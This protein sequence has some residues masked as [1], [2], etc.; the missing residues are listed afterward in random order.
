MP[1]TFDIRFRLNARAI[2]ITVPAEALLLDVVRDRLG[3]KGAKRS[4]DMQVCGACTVLVDGAPVS[5]C[6]YLAI[7]VDGRRVL[8]VEGLGTAERLDPLQDA[9]MDHA[10]VQCGFCTAGML[11][12]AIPSTSTVHAPHTCM[13]HER[14]A[15]FRSSRSRRTS[16]SSACAGTASSCRRPLTVRRRSD[17]DCSPSGPI[18]TW[19]GR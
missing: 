18:L 12:T 2:A 16:R 1:A 4:C 9:F 15:P 14:L 7:E 13:S 3:L 5:A 11:L 6:T 8:T 19:P 17:T 10:A